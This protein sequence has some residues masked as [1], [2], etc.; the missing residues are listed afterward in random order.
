MQAASKTGHVIL[1]FS[2]SVG[3]ANCT[4]SWCLRWQRL[5]AMLWTI[6][7]YPIC[8]CLC[9]GE[10]GNGSPNPKADIVPPTH[11]AQLCQEK[12][13]LLHSLRF[14]DLWVL[15]L[16]L[17]CLQPMFSGVSLCPSF[18]REDAEKKSR[19]IRGREGEMGVK[20][21]LAVGRRVEFSV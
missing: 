11:L 18:I 4:F 20:M 13:R 17:C 12:V 7:P 5:T 9:E 14:I 2:E 21:S 1:F 8:C 15:L 16:V 19:L 3:A 10:E 6:H